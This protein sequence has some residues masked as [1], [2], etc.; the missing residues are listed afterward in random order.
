MTLGK[1]QISRAGHCQLGSILANDNI[2][3]SQGTGLATNLDLLL[4]IGF[5][6]AHVQDLVVHRL[7]A[8]NDELDDILLSLDLLNDGLRVV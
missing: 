7:R 1:F 5:E 6:K 2:A 3:G 8:V 4:Q